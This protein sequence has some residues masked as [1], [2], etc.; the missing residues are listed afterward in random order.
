MTELVRL[1]PLATVPP[2]GPNGERVENRTYVSKMQLRRPG[3]PRLMPL[4]QCAA[5]RQPRIPRCVSSVI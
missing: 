5:L 2:R 3:P 1:A 4:T